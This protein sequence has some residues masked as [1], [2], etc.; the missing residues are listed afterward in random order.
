VDV[1]VLL[2]AGVLFMGVP[3]AVRVTDSCDGVCTETE[4]AL[5]VVLP[6]ETVVWA[7]DALEAALEGVPDAE[8]EGVGLLVCVAL[9]LDSA[10]LSPPLALAPDWAPVAT[11][12]AAAAA[13]AAASAAAFAAARAVPTSRLG[14]R[15]YG[16]GGAL[17]AAAVSAVSLRRADADTTCDASRGNAGGGNG[18]VL[19]DLLASLASDKIW[20]DSGNIV[21]ARQTMHK[22]IKV[23]CLPGVG[24]TVSGH[25]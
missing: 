24:E 13:A 5:E 18:A 12:A 22:Y 9:R 10:E 23:A 16:Y 2:E 4:A 17:V 11:A 25:R 14:G 21:S 3:V 6:L 15:W 20:K 1:S 19:P 7:C 8:P